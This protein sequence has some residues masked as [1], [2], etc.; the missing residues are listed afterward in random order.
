MGRFHYDGKGYPRWNDSNELVHRTVNRTPEGMHTHH[1]DGD[2]G[3][4]KR[5]NL[6][7]ISP[8]DHGRVHARMRE[9]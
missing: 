4:F 2:K 5:E 3:N 9:D 6:G 7:T 8:S 1:R